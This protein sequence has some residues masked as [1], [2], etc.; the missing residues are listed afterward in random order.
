MKTDKIL[1]LLVAATGHEPQ[2]LIRSL[3]SKLR[4]GL[5]EQTVLAALAHASILTQPNPHIE[6][7]S[8]SLKQAEETLKSIYCECPSYDLIIPNLLQFGLTETLNKCQLTPGI[9]VKPMLAKRASSVDELFEKFGEDAFTCEYK[10]DGE[11]AQIHQIADGSVKI[12]SRNLE[13]NTGKYPDVILKIQNA[14]KKG[15]GCETFILDCEVVG[16]QNGKILPFQT[17]MTRGR[18][19][20]QVQDIKIDVCLFLFDILCL[21]GKSLLKEPLSERRKKLYHCFERIEGSVHFAVSLDSKDV[22]EIQDFLSQSMKNSCE[23]IM[24]KTINTSYEPARRST[25]WLKL[26][27]DYIKGI[28]DS[29]DLVP[30]G[31]YLGKGKRTG[32]YGGYLLACYNPDTEEYESICKLGTGF[33]DEDLQLI[34][35]DMDEI[36]VDGVKSYYK[37]DDSL[38][39]DVW[40]DCKKVWEIKAAD[41]TLSPKHMAAIGLIDELKGIALR[42][43]R[44]IRMREDKAVEDATSSQE[45]AEMFRKQSAIISRSNNDKGP[46]DSESENE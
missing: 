14:I 17:L 3:Q 13:N 25:N 46:G 22:E 11:R 45:I 38:K 10:Y 30:I 29:L 16:Y 4:I 43:P 26:K 2:F 20:I 6:I 1:H 5:A 39:P 34:A 44:F 28:G 36:K 31:G 37:V 18:K 15:S 41:L 42:F 19:N 35:K 12:F 21:N 7:S 33:S 32:L 40:F 24:I 9:P 23:G 8:E 27:K